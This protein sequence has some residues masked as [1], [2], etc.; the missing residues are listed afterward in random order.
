[1]NSVQVLVLRVCQSGADVHSPFREQCHMYT[2]EIMTN[3]KNTQSWEGRDEVLLK[4][5]I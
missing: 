5:V 4:I 3:S 1:M 2:Q